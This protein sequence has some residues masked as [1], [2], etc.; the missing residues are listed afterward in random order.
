MQV[1]DGRMFHVAEDPIHIPRFMGTTNDLLF[2]PF[3]ARAKAYD[4]VRFVERTKLSNGCTKVLVFGHLNVIGA[5]DGSETEDF[6]RGREVVFPTDALL[7]KWG[8]RCLLFNG[9]YHRRQ[10]VRGVRMPGA[11]GRLGFGEVGNPAGVL[12]VEV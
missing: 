12:I 4:P 7:A 10:V 5:D 2:F 9:H 1:L 8:D 6:P 3:T 11:L